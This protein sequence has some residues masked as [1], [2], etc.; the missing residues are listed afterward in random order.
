MTAA[1]G[2]E[3]E[4]WQVGARH[5]PGG[6]LLGLIRNSVLILKGVGRSQGLGDGIWKCHSGCHVGHVLDLSRRWWGAGTGRCRQVSE[7][8]RQVEKGGGP[9]DRL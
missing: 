4:D 2:T 5:R 7:E 9:R 6:V 3:R 1:L 8:E